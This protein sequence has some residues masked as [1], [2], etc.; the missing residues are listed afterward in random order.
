[1]V[2]VGDFMIAEASAGIEQKEEKVAKKKG[3]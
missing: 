2:E 3:A 1:M